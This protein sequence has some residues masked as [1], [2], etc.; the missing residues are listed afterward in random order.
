MPVYDDQETRTRADDE[1]LRRIT[2]IDENEEAQIE[3]D[4]VH[5]GSTAERE[6]LDAKTGNP[7]EEDTQ[8]DA[9]KPQSGND[10]SED[11]DEEKDDSDS[12]YTGSGSKKGMR[13]LVA[14][15]R[16]IPSAK[17]WLIAF[18]AGLM[19]T[20]VGGFVAFI[21]FLLPFKVTHAI[22]QIEQRLGEVPQYAVEQRLQYYM[23]RY[24]ILRTLAATPGIGEDGINSRNYVY[25]EGGV[26]G[27]LYINW[28]GANLE[29]KL[30]AQG[31]RLEPANNNAA[32]IF[33]RR[34]VRPTEWNLINDNA[35]ANLRS[36]S[37]N[38]QEARAFIKE[39]AKSETKS[40]QVFKRYNMRKMLKRYYGV[41]NWKFFET[42][43]NDIRRSYLDKKLAYKK[44]LVEKTVG[45]ISPRYSA[46]MTCLLEGASACRDALGRGTDIDANDGDPENRD[47]ET[48]ESTG[49]GGEE[50][51]QAAA[52]G[53][54]DSLPSE[55][56]DIVNPDTINLPDIPGGGT[57]EVVARSITAQIQKLGVKKILAS[58]AAGIGLID[59]IAQMV[60]SVESGALNIVVMDK[61][62]QQY[63]NYAAPVLS[64]AD[65]IRAGD[66]NIDDA[67]YLNETFNNFQSS[68]VYQA[69]F[70]GR[71]GAL[72]A[73]AT[74]NGQIRRD[75]NN[76]QDTD[77]EGELFAPGETVCPGKRLVQDKT[78]FTDNT[79]WERLVEITSVYRGSVGAI[80]G[81]LTGLVSR[82]TDAL[83]LD[84]IIE[85]VMS[86]L[87]LD[88]V[89]ASAFEFLLNRVAG[90]VITGV[91]VEEE[92][93]DALYAGMT[94]NYS[95]IGGGVG[96]NREDTT[97]G[98]Y[99]PEAQV[100]AI[101]NEAAEE[102]QY[103]KKFES[104][105]E[106][107]LSLENT[108][109]LA[110]KT[111]MNV[112]TSWEQLATTVAAI[113]TSLVRSFGSIMG[114]TAGAQTINS[115]N[116]FHA[117]WM[118]YP[119]N[120]PIFTANDGAGMDEAQMEAEYR[121]SLPVAQRPQNNPDTYD[122]P[123]NLPFDVA[124]LADPCLL[125][126][127]VGDVGN[128]YLDG[129]YDE[130]LSD[131]ATNTPSGGNTNTGA[132][133][134]YIPDCSVN[135]GNA[136]IACTAIDQLLG[137]PY[138]MAQRA[139]PNNPDPDFLDC[140]AF[141]NM[142]IYRTFSNNL[143]GMCSAQFRNNPNFEF[144]NVHEIQPG[145]I[146]GRGTSCVAGGGNGHV[147]IVVSYDRSTRA[148]VTAETDGRANPSRIVT[149]KGLRIDNAG[150]YEWAV[151]YI[152]PQ[153]PA[154]GGAQ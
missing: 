30:A 23:N 140:S 77:D 119:T 43:R 90:P 103:A 128:R 91:E 59:T 98:G 74:V 66:A 122:R 141:V 129:T 47:P 38:S 78:T 114:S 27:S 132:S 152:G 111:L 25:L 95:S 144:V 64:M 110:T 96:V 105:S 84:S 28:R 20:L 133:A 4:A 85:S 124:M 112:P 55:A 5:D 136:A 75:C 3:E 145:D 121:C 35:P 19:A 11:E 70:G 56:S 127:V 151:R 39:W 7:D 116:P 130:G 72:S 58:F 29:G 22:S 46:Y 125:E 51:R 107:Y 138:S 61:N 104:L 33:N 40:I 18:G 49:G 97:G 150:T 10:K 1:E 106:R 100:N 79:L 126:E 115:T 154:V 142:A 13:G 36:Q 42:E 86:A 109:S 34:S 143:G 131:G 62:S 102:R 45:S 17:K 123:D 53:E 76:D 83:G 73:Q 148:L 94:V 80:V 68:P 139:A 147:G 31:W 44:K 88:Q 117:I 21:A 93:Y 69:E 92:A 24:L 8:N 153:G 14:R 89:L 99:L 149:N 15:F 37:L 120:H 32:Q 50:S 137:I 134:Q 60:D 54:M 135:G 87:G 113:P 108:D 16:R 82:V 9:D 71:S 63:A 2:G 146:L 12:L 48:G 118:G 52:S 26:F 65:Q 57:D 41:N 81:G 6:A 67:R 101:R